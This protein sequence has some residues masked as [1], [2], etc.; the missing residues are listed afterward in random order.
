M[1]Q[2]NTDRGTKK[3]SD[4]LAL[5]LLIM[6]P[7]G[8]ML[9]AAWMYFGG[10]LLPDGRTHKGNLLNPPLTLSAFENPELTSDT[11]D[12][13][14]G[15]LIVAGD[16][17]DAVCRDVLFLTRQIHIALDRDTRRVQRHL[18]MPSL[19]AGETKEFSAFLAEEHIGLKL[20]EGEMPAFTSEPDSDMASDDVRVFLTDPMG[21][22]MLWYGK[23]HNGKQM[24]NDLKKLLKV[25][26]VG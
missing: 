7:F 9:L 17:C 4:K 20:I 21:N 14:W 3:K 23:E 1:M 8:G 18:L 16:Q 11:L 10:Q 5:L 24:L 22:I 15:I 25:S 2:T 19:D 12:D 26:R 6:I 13:R